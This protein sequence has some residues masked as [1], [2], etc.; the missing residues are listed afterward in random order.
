MRILD[1]KSN[2]ISAR[3]S[4][5]RSYFTKL[6]FY[7]IRLATEQHHYLFGFVNSLVHLSVYDAYVSCNLFVFF[8]SIR[9]NTKYACCLTLTTCYIDIAMSI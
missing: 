8:I 5:N 6:Q 1:Y 2:E 3:R 7:S 4:L 9:N